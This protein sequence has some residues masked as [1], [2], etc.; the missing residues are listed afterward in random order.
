MKKNR[1]LVICRA[2]DH[3]LHPQWLAPVAEKNFDLWIDYYGNE[4]NKYL[5]DCDRYSEAKGPK[6][7]RIHELIE[8]LQDKV[9]EYDAV[10][11]PDDDLSADGTT[12]NRMFQCFTE[13]E[14]SLAQP[15][16]TKDSYY[17]HWITLRNSGLTLRYTNFV[18]IMAPL[19]S[20]DALK[21]CWPTF[22]RNFT[23]WGLDYIWP[24]ILSGKKIA[25][26]DKTPIW[27]TRPIGGGDLYKA[28]QVDSWQE[29][30]QTIDAYNIKLPYDFQIT[31]GLIT[32]PK[33]GPR[34][35]LPGPNSPG[36]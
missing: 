23:G 10:W 14:L 6:W 17:S 24:T 20:R 36:Y 19:F 12:I 13:Y 5:N 1:F 7:A 29:L 35:L 2:G 30:E 33:N 26:M 9:F 21:S 28:S 32:P 18:E 34:L 15:A 22:N 25:I 3:S 16:L 4:H 8:E 11:F 27:H 31:S